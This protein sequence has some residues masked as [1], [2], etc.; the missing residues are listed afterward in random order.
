MRC[1]GEDITG[2]GEDRF[3]GQKEL[4]EVHEGRPEI[5]PRIGESHST[6]LL[7]TQHTMQDS[8][9]FTARVKKQKDS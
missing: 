5:F 9:C 7:V 2:F 1:Q 8:K 3:I 6:S 4:K